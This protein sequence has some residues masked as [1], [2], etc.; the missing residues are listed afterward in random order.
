MSKKKHGQ[1]KSEGEGRKQMTIKNKSKRE[2][3]SI[4]S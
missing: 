3:N 2:E 1:N 4:K